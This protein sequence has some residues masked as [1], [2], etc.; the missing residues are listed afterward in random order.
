MNNQ[1]GAVAANGQRPQ[2]QQQQGGIMGIISTLIRFMAIYY[3]ASF[4]FSKFLGTNNT[5]T[6][7]GGVVLN[8]N[9]ASTN[10]NVASS[11]NSI[12]LANSWPEGIEFNMKVYLST[13]N[14]T[15]GDWLVWEQDK[16]SY[17]WK[18]SNTIPIKNITF[19]TTPYLQNNGSLFA[20]II[21]TRRPYLNQPKSQLHK[22]HPLIVYLPKPKPKGKNLLEE[23]S[24][25]EPEVEYDPT[26]LIS[27]WKPTLSLHLIV[28]HTIYPPD[29]IPREIVSYFNI[30]NGF[31]SPIIYCNEFWLYREH[32]YPVNETVKQLSIEISY[33]SMGLFKWQLQ[34]QMQKSLDMQESFG[35]TSAM[36][37]SVG[38]E[39]KRMLTDNDP[40][41]LGLT[42]IVSVLHTVFEFLAFKNDIQ[43]WKNNKSMEGLS[44]KTITL[45][46]VC[47]GIIFLYLLDNETSYMILA[48]SGFGFLVEFWKL[49]KAMTIKITWMDSLPLPKRIQFIN[50]DEYVSKTKQYDDMAM[51]YLSWALFPLVI[52]TSIYSLYYHEHKSWYSWVVSSLV[53]TVYTFEFIMMTPQL[54]I[55]YKLK[56][57]SHLPWRVFMYRALNTFIDDLFAFIIK[58][59]LLH[60]LSC[61]RD[62]IIFIVYLYQRWI[63][64][65][66]KK[67]SHY[68]SE[69]DDDPAILLQQNKDQEKEKEKEN[70]EENKKKKEIKEQKDEKIE[71]EQQ[72]E[73]TTSSSKITKRKTKKV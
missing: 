20:H 59:P 35:G 58:M 13:S 71:E 9:N 21:T 32:L 43:F 65:V 66:D 61:L 6:N 42:L 12:R 46:C 25:D 14:E 70:E 27:Y 10:T 18:D 55:N 1:G 62:D 23:K 11:S 53:R 54:F 60:R 24:N 40:W 28:D 5:G 45:N 29:S 69:E 67:R 7:N 33:S 41:I 47:M 50:K 3:I 52:G 8:D 4:A 31:Y 19:D 38:D 17:D 64:P 30:T 49:G 37:G 68:G 73:E 2:A 22:V 56:S 48:S 16:L 39:F 72:E 36:G 44:V 51:K 15:V 57:V 63:Y 34:I 26:E